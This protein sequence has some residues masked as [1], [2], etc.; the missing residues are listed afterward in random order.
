MFPSASFVSS[1]D[2]AA[3]DPQSGYDVHHIVERASA[4]NADEK[5]RIMQPDNEVLIPMLKHWELN[6]WYARKDVRFGGLSPRDYLEG[7]SWGERQR[8]GLIGLRA[9]GVLK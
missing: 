2:V 4:Q 7:K 8:V 9:V 6:G 5:I 3:L 1:F